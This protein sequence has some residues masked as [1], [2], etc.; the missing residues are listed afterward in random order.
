MGGIDSPSLPRR[1]IAYLGG[2][3]EAIHL[4]TLTVT[5]PP[6]QLRKE[7]FLNYQTFLAPWRSLSATSGRA[8]GM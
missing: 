5:M 2:L 4:L 6:P 8:D 3:Y 7:I 1:S